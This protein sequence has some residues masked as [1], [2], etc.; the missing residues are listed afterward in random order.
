V[1]IEDALRM[2]RGLLA[3]HNLTG[4]TVVADRAKTRAGVCRFAQR[5]IGLSR[6]LTEVHSEAEVRDTILHEIAHALVGPGHGHDHV[7]RATAQ[8]IGSSGQRCVPSEAPRL[9]TAWSGV[10]PAGHVHSRHKAPS[11]VVTCGRCSRRFDIT[12]LIEWTYRGAVVPMPDS[13]AA[14]LR[15]LLG[16]GAVRPP[17]PSG[18]RSPDVAP[19]L[20]RR[21]EVG[22][23]VRVLEGSVWAGAVGEVEFV[24]SVRVQVRLGEDLVSIPSSGL[25]LAEAERKGGHG[26]ASGGERRAWGVGE[27]GGAGPTGFSA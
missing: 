3:E 12:H 25:G 20:A 6:P 26:E 2:A 4:W 13:Y 10:C 5:Q 19:T 24:G 15:Q 21:L 1:R 17:R 18:A 27:L 8:A 23:Q 11:R 16:S 9:P 7:W 14:Q 22:D